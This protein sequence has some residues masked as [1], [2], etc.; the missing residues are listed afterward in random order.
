MRGP[1]DFSPTV[2]PRP[3]PPDWKEPAYKDIVRDVFRFR[4]SLRLPLVNYPGV[5]G[6]W[7]SFQETVGAQP[8]LC[9]CSREA[10]VGFLRLNQ[11]H[12]TYRLGPSHSLFDHFLWG[13]TA[14]ANKFR[15]GTITEFEA[16]AIFVDGICHL[17][18]RRVPSVRWSNLGEHSVFLQHFGWYA[19]MAMYAAG[20]DP[21]GDFIPSMLDSE[22]QTFLEVEPVS[23]REQINEFLTR[24]RL[25]SGVLDRPSSP[26]DDRR[27][28][29]A[30]I[31]R[32][33]HAMT[34]QTRAMKHCV[35]ARLRSSLGFPRTAKLG[36]R[37]QSSS[38]S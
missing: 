15:A 16:S 6:T 1:F 7:I 24:H 9:G 12:Q 8:H 27:P 28:G 2:Q 18:S 30:D 20:L 26:S 31:R 3:V 23:A 38:G 25:W 29:M 32:L 22:L 13:D 14:A 21:I 34:R 4:E 36:C 33:R 10:C 19:L 11:Q 35:E 5:Y 37:S 17:C